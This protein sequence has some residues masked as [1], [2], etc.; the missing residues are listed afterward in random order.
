MG[1]LTHVQCTAQGLVS[2]G[3]RSPVDA[4]AAQQADATLMTRILLC[5][6]VA[7]RI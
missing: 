6:L 7:F 1:G 5:L 2:G 4:A 3:A